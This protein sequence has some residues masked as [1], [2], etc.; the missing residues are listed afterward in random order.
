MS[1]TT[2]I[3][4]FA[5]VVFLAVKYIEATNYQVYTQ[6]GLS[7]VNQSQAALNYAQA[8]KVNQDV[9]RQNEFD[10]GTAINAVA[11]VITG[12]G[13]T[14]AEQLGGTLLAIL[15]ACGL[16]PWVALFGM[17]IAWKLTRPVVVKHE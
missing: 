7:E 17:F 12:R 2:K 16:V 8:E 13:I 5:A 14:D 4:L 11:R 10:D 1:K 6:P 3:L 15:S 9:R